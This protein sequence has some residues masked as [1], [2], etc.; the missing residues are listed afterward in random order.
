LTDDQLDQVEGN[1]VKLSDVI[2]EN[3]GIARDEADK[4]ISEWEKKNDRAA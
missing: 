2:Q 3:Y 4:Q 1:R